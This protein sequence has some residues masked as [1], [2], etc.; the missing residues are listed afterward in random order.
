M[1]EAN[2]KRFTVLPSAN[3]VILFLWRQLKSELDQEEFSSSS[4]DQESSRFPTKFK[5]LSLLLYKNVLPL[6]ASDFPHSSYLFY[7]VFPLLS[8]PSRTLFLVLADGRVV[9]LGSVSFGRSSR[10]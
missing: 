2:P 9:G 6:W 8:I 5:I 4:D 10:C 7:F 1:E 3:D